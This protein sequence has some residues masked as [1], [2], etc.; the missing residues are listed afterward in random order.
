MLKPLDKS[1]GN[2]FPGTS[3]I[4]D[5]S[6]GMLLHTL[7]LASAKGMLLQTMPLAS[8]NGCCTIN[9]SWALAPSLILWL[10]PPEY[11]AKIFFKHCRWL[12]PT[13]PELSN[14]SRALAPFFNSLASA[15]RVLSN[16]FLQ[17]IAVGF[18]PEIICPAFSKRLL[19]R[20]IAVGFSQRAR[21]SH[22]TAGL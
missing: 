7:P 4:P 6:H 8:A 22:T 13:V 12:Q 20:N 16:N 14:D 11:S 1:N 5:F 15:T 17:N 3:I 9:D 18:S 19:L 2:E 21:N 10:Q